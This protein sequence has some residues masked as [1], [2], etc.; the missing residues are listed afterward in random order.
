MGGL[1]EGG[2]ESSMDGTALFGRTLA[3]T[4]EDVEG[5]L[6]IFFKSFF[7]IDGA[8]PL[9]SCELFAVGVTLYSW[10]S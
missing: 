5:F 2:S 3:A 1:G 7:T 9:L 10:I 8:T 6:Q 4:V